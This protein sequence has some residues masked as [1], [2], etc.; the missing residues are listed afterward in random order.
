MVPELRRFTSIANIREGTS[1]HGFPGS[2][3][4]KNPP[5]TQETKKTQVR[6]PGWENP[7]EEEMATHSSILVGKILWTEEPG[8]LQSMGPQKVGPD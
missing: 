4:V 8:R 3:M 1:I 2:A 7:L 5:A 6:S